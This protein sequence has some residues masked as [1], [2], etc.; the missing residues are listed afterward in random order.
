[1]ANITSV[2]SCSGKQIS[3]QIHTWESRFLST[4]Y[5]C[6]NLETHLN[7][8]PC[9][10]G[11]TATLLPLLTSLCCYFLER[12]RACGV[13]SAQ[14]CSW[15]LWCEPPCAPFWL[16]ATQSP[17]DQSGYDRIYS[18]SVFLFPKRVSYV[19]IP[20]LYANNRSYK[21]WWMSDQRWAEFNCSCLTE[22][23]TGD[24]ANIYW[25]LLCMASQILSLGTCSPP[26]VEAGF[27]EENWLLA[28][29]PPQMKETRSLWRPSQ[30]A[31]ESSSL[32]HMKF[33]H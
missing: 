4:F 27:L 11:F 1:M 20:Q 19:W 7:K 14:A 25:F 12:S 8:L 29:Q 16:W 22:A 5:I 17:P 18:D 32:F 23:W 10:Y 21:K 6:E 9:A 33:V 28:T 3:E 30:A 13:C 26:K 31:Q 24:R 15:E 2:S